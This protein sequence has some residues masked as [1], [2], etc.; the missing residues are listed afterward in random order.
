MARATKSK[1]AGMTPAQFRRLAKA[2]CAA[3]PLVLALGDEPF[4]RREVRG[5][6]KEVRP[7]AERHEV[8]AQKRG[9]DPALVLDEL[10]SA[11]LFHSNKLVIVTNAEPFVAQAGE[12]IVAFAEA[13]P[14]GRQLLLEMQKLD[15]R[16]KVGKRIHK[17]ALIVTCK[18][19]FAEKAPWQ[20]GPD[21]DTPLSQ[22]IVKRFAAQGKRIA[23]ESA[24]GLAQI[25]GN[26]LGAID[27]TVEKLCVMLGDAPD[28]SDDVLAKVASHTRRDN[29]FAIAEAIGK[30]DGSRA[31]RLCRG[32]FAR[33]LRAGDSTVTDASGIALITLGAIH[34]TFRDIRRA[35][36]YLADG[37]SP[38][39]RALAAAIGVAPFAAD[40]VLAQAQA[41]RRVSLDACYRALL[42]CDLGIKGAAGGRLALE[43]LVVELGALR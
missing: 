24:Y 37:G 36:A 34:R 43:R 32:A 17:L 35:L 33:G 14:K 4:F 38:N 2:K 19:L 42:R 13:A 16:T 9:Q 18:R 26:D 5:R 22:W 15:R 30:R 10:R 21:W 28:V 12:A 11:S 6:L 41:H 39:G 25:T 31:L 29:A 8:A 7:D 40:R 20:R 1:S 27:Q 3:A 23:G